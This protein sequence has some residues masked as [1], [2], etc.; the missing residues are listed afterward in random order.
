MSGKYD[1]IIDLPHHVSARHPQMPN[2]D[3]AAQ[4]SPFAALTG[5]EAVIN[6]TSR[7]TD[8]KADLDE[9]EISVISERLNSIM[10]DIA[11]HPIVEVTYFHPDEKKSG[12]KYISITDGIKKIDESEHV[13][14]MCNGTK[15]LIDDIYAISMG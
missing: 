12:G 9:Y 1:D 13:L 11:S 15:I 6:E 5:F 7:L 10:R 14:I 8:R 4:F 3:R 2:S